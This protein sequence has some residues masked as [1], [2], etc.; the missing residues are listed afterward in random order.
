[1][2]ENEAEW[3]ERA[4]ELGSRALARVVADAAGE[5]APKVRVTF[6]FSN[7]QYADL[8]DAIRALRRERNEAVGREEALIE[9]V[10]R[11]AAGAARGA[12]APFRVVIYKCDVCAHVGRETREGPI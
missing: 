2:A 3:I 5:P 1:T 9:L 10:R 8:E 4:K 11:G 7:E 12:Q 6:E